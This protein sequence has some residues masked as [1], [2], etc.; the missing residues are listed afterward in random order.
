MK[1]PIVFFTILVIYLFV[2]GCHKDSG[3]DGSGSSNIS[4]L[5]YQDYPCGSY[6]GAAKLNSSDDYLYHYSY[7]DGVLELDF[8]FSNTCGCAYEDSVV[9]EDNQIYLFLNDTASIH[10]KCICQHRS[11]FHLRLPENYESI[12]LELQINP[13]AHDEYYVC[14]DTL[15]D[16]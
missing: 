10:A 16:L 1:Q 6:G 14:V 15:L 8:R 11:V 3:T 9:I 2:A 12:R 13:Y 5:S 7:D 4:F